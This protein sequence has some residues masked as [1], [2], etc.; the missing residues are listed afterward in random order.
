MNR[1]VVGVSVVMAGVVTSL[2]AQAPA[3][4]QVAFLKA[5]NA[6]AADHFGNGG[7]LLGDSVSISGDGNTIAVGAPHEASSS[8]GINGNQND[9]SSYNAG[10]VYVFP[11]WGTHGRS[12]PISRRRT[13][14]RAIIS[15]I[16]SP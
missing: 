13:P 12:R 14:R 3:V 2:L 1:A 10:A 6:D 15:A 8:S 4:R 16:T 5:S 11:A 9:N 7:T